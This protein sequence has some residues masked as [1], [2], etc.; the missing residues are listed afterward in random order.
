MSDFSQRDQ[1]MEAAQ[2]A[3][4]DAPEAVRGGFL[5]FVAHEMRNPLAT[6]LWSAE[7]LARLTPEERGGARGEKLAG[8]ALRALQ[9]LRLLVEDHFLAERLDVQGIPLRI[10]AVRLREALDGVLGKAGL[11]G[12]IVDCDEALAVRVD[13]TLLDRA[14]DGLLAAASRGK[15]PVRIEASTTG[16][17]VVVRVSGAAI[18]ADALAPPRKGTPSDATGR[19]LALYV[20]LRV[21]QALGGSL[22]IDAD[23]YVLT[24]CCG[25]GSGPVPG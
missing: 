21:A 12:V 8:M 23:A 15:A 2:H 14:L 16:G 19:G 11:E 7:L 1:P 22:A 20:A 9:R 4:G 24:L 6:A 25:V 13:R 17:D 5:G 3:S 10:E 18:P